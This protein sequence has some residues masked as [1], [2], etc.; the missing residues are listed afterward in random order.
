[1]ALGSTQPHTQWV[2]GIL[3]LFA[4]GVNWL[5][6]E[7]DHSPPPSAKVMHEWN[8]PS[9]PP[10]FRCDMHRNFILRTGSIYFF[11]NTQSAINS[12]HYLASTTAPSPQLQ[13]KSFCFKPHSWYHFSS[14]NVW[15]VFPHIMPACHAS[16]EDQVS[17]WPSYNAT[18]P[19]P[20]NVQK[21]A[22]R[23]W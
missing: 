8:Y 12:L 18:L 23:R 14:I 17:A 16:A 22:F 4:Q 5:Q 9:T 19:N 13:Q 21:A 20:K 10:I 6:Y 15:K 3:W 11:H 1:M 7:A 2:S